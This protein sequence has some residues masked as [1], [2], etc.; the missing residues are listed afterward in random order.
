MESMESMESLYHYCDNNRTV[1]SFSSF[2][3]CLH[4]VLKRMM[5]E[6]NALFKVCGNVNVSS[7]LFNHL[8]I[9]QTQLF[10]SSYLAELET[11]TFDTNLE[12]HSRTHNTKYVLTQESG[13]ELLMRTH[14]DFAGATLY[15]PLRALINELKNVLS[16]TNKTQCTTKYATKHAP[17]PTKPQTANELLNASAL[18]ISNA[19]ETSANL[20]SAPKIDKTSLFDNTEK[21]ESNDESTDNES[22][23]DPDELLKNIHKLEQAS[24]LI[25][26]TINEGN[27]E[28]HNEKDNLANFIC[29]V[30]EENRAKK[31]EEEKKQQAKNVFLS[32]KEHTYPLIYN[33]FY[34]RKK[35]DGF[36]NL[37]PLFIA[38]FPVFLF[39]DGKDLNGNDV[40]EKLLGRDDECELYDLLLNSITDDE[41]D[42]PENDEYLAILKEFNNQLPEF[43]FVSCEDIMQGLNDADDN[44]LFNQSECSGDDVSDSDEEYVADN[45]RGNKGRKANASYGGV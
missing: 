45:M 15:F 36:A 20:G 37:P 26:E 3:L 12:V 28:L 17:V 40:R 27:E 22:T 42:L 6:A 25:K 21:V 11:Y 4:A 16:S 30:N 19:L 35:F 7:N 31:Y 44:P 23:I 41:F 2:A 24:S 10:E 39:L 38:K 5:N 18:L 8:S 1:A 34:V 32:E 9:T 43:D 13:F 29:R 14:S 33:D